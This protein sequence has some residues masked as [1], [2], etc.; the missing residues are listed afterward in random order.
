MHETPRSAER[1]VDSRSAGAR[2]SRPASEPAQSARID[3]R[4][5]ARGV[6][7]S[8]PVVLASTALPA[9]AVST[10]LYTIDWSTLNN[11]SVTAYSNAPGAAGR[12]VTVAVGGT[13]AGKFAVAGVTNT[14]AASGTNAVNLATSFGGAAV[15]ATTGYYVPTVDY[16]TLTLTFPNNTPGI[17][18]TINSV[19]PGSYMSTTYQLTAN[20]TPVNPTSTNATIDNQTYSGGV[21]A[22]TYAYGSTTG[23]STS[24]Y[25][26][27]TATTLSLLMYDGY[28]ASAASRPSAY[29]MQLGIVSFF[30]NV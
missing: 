1:P 27:M 10:Y 30:A 6:A 28:R 24:T 12:T 7:W 26:G 8:A 16:R 15:G 21:P 14:I 22:P 5:L 18:L 19:T 29:R 17:S 20:G 25:S 23:S 3:R 11:G 2:S 9:F 13:T 4:S